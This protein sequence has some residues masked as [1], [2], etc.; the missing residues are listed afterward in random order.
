L[1]DEELDR[2]LRNIQGL[3]LLEAEKILTR[4]IVED[5]KL[6]ADDIARVVEAKKEIVERE[7]LLEY[8]PAEETMAAI[9]GLAGLKAWLA[10]RRELLTRPEE[11]E[12]FGLS[13]PK[14]I[15]LL[16]VQGCGKSLCAKVTAA[17]WGLPLLKLDPSGLY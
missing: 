10:K 17:E 9:A 16:G 14:G 6:S 7:G 8:H 12:R 1:R 5:G 13:F 15:L 2:L 3:T 4:A 11:A